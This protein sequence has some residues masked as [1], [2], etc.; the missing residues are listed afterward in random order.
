MKDHTSQPDVQMECDGA[1][2]LI[3]AM[4]IVTATLVAVGYVHNIELTPAYR[5]T[6]IYGV[7]GYM[8]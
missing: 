7:S 8:F 1:A 2:L 5:A 4:F 3:L 6:A